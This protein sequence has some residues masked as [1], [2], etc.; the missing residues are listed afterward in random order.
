VLS[1]QEF[2][3]PL[4]EALADGE[5]HRL[6]DLTKRV[7][8]RFGLTESDWSEMLP[9]RQQTVISNRIAWAKTYLKKAGLVK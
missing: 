9:S 6:R 1:Y 2:M 4:L 7:A 8:D 5:E 3:L